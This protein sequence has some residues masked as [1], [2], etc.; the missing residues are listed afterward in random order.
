MRESLA[1][2]AARNSR[3][4]RDSQ[5]A[6]VRLGQKNRYPRWHVPMETER[7]SGN[8][9]LTYLD[10][11]TLLLV[12]MLVLL[13]YAHLNP[14]AA[15]AGP[16][17]HAPAAPVALARP[18]GGMAP[19]DWGMPLPVSAVPTAPS[20]WPAPEQAPLP[21]TGPVDAAADAGAIAQ[22]PEAPASP[23]PADAAS[24]T[25]QPAPGP[26]PTV[27]AA[28]SGEAQ[29]PAA[30]PLTDAASTIPPAP[31]SGDAAPSAPVSVDSAPTFADPA[32]AATDTAPA[33]ADP[34]PASPAP[35]SKAA[36]PRGDAPPSLED[37]GLAELGKDVAVIV[38]KE[39]ISLRISSEILFSSGQ[40]ALTPAGL[41]V[42]D[43]LAAALNRNAYRI[44]VEGHTDPVPIRT[45][46]FPSNWELSTARAT[47]VLRALESRGIAARRLRATGY[48]DT[49]PIASN[50]Q[51]SGRAANRRVELILETR[52]AP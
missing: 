18:L 24:A 41:G 48:A 51:A 9:L 8:W 46:R 22:D 15:H 13:A 19:A 4:A 20:R 1:D 21:G 23:L 5:R 33:S 25:R 3:L 37:L 17:A 31:S 7:E 52:P 43:T 47:S 38:N 45:D 36:P 42:L 16:D 34:G 39:S 32:P 2:I 26:L 40:A 6:R 11:L 27:A 29:A 50:D 30:G 28:A 12:M 49:R 44:A 14:K 10:L 35:A